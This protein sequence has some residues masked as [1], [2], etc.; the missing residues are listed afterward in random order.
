M[1]GLIISQK[2]SIRDE[3]KKTMA[4]ERRRNECHFFFFL[5]FLVG[6]TNAISPTR[7][8]EQKRKP[9]GNEISEQKHIT[10]A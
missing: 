6:E 3:R 5:F 10:D 7:K 1:L 8:T 4:K 9:E 2:N